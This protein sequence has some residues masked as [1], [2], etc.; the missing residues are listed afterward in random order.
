MRIYDS[1]IGS[2]VGEVDITHYYSK[3]DKRYKKDIEFIPLLAFEH[4]YHMLLLKA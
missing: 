1:A 4:V 2:V 3:Q